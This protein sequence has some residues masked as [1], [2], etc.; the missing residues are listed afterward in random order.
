MY[1]ISHKRVLHSDCILT[2]SNS[3]LRLRF[4]SALFYIFNFCYLLIACRDVISD[5]GPRFLNS[6]LARPR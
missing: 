6:S 4:M 2:Y 3:A 1:C 5:T